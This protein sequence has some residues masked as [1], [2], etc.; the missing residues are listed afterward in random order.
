MYMLLAIATR[1][2]YAVGAHISPENE[3]MPSTENRRDLRRL[4]FVCYMM[5]KDLTMRTGKAPA[6]ND[7][8]VDFS[9]NE[10]L[11]DTAD[12]KHLIEMD[13]GK[14][15][16]IFCMM[17]QLATIKSET[18]SRLYSVQVKHTIKRD[19]LESYQ[20]VRCSSC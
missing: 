3:N 1:K 4:F 19:L 14:R 6:I 17:L 16:S 2:L 13:N 12:P 15:T 7:D 18:Y 20:G 5:D 10:F 9:F 8:E 11:L